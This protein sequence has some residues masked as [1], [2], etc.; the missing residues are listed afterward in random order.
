MGSVLTKLLDYGGFRG[1][2]CVIELP[3]EE[4]KEE[5]FGLMMHS[6]CDETLCLTMKFKEV[7]RILDIDAEKASVKDRSVDWPDAGVYNV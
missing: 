4:E 3:L 6:F 5:Q 2:G 1:C 7:Y